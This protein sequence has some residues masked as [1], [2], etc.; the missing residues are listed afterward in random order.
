MSY[1][2]GQQLLLPES[3]RKQRKERRV[4]I[5]VNSGDRNL[6]ANYSPNNFKCVF[7]RP[8]KDIISV[9]LIGGCIPA[10]LY[11]VTE[12]WNKFIFTESINRYTITLTPGQYTA[13]QLATELQTQLN[14]TATLNTYSATFH[15]ITKK[16]EIRRITG[17]EQYALLFETGTPY[18]DSINSYTGAIERILSPAKLLGFGIWDYPSPP[19]GLIISPNRMDPDY[20]IK[21]A[22]IHINADNSIE[23]N[24]IE[25]G[26]GR[27]D[28]FHIAY[29]DTSTD[30]Y[31]YFNKD[32][33]APIFYSSPAPISRM[34]FMT[35]SIR[36]EYYRL[37]DLG[38]HDFTLIFE[39]TSLE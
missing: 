23:L 22:Y 15:T 29:M 5:A 12:E 17:W 39:I 8:L 6:T 36:D 27:H 4:T 32:V 19:N 11:N 26:G 13:S 34:S 16:L 18:V 24:R 10:D 9:E 20:C 31:F 38:G 3:T 28:C 14:A 25:S 37:I 35:I 1:T 30:G 21:R 33:Y 2:S 7:R